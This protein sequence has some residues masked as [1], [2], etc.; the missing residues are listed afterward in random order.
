MTPNEREFVEEARAKLAE[1]DRKRMDGTLAQ[2]IR[3]DFLRLRAMYPHIPVGK[4]NP[5]PRRRIKQ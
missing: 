1:Y 2:E 5:F 3:A 4:I